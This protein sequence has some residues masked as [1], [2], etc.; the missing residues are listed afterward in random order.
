[1]GLSE[2]PVPGRERSGL[3]VERGRR[4]YCEGREEGEDGKREKEV[5]EVKRRRIKGGR[6]R[7]HIVPSPAARERVVPQ[8]PALKPT[9]PPF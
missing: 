4:R 9:V 5:K 7:G 1:L 6:G 8:P 3:K 2:S